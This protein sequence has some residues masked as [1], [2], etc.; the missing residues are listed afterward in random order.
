MVTICLYSLKFHFKILYVFY[1]QDDKFPYHV[2]DMVGLRWLKLNKT[3]L[4][5]V[6][7]ELSNLR[8]LVSDPNIL[9]DFASL[10]TLQL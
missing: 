5:V 8:K 7:F 1:A 4:D 2:T 6:P 9:Y 3:N 10:V